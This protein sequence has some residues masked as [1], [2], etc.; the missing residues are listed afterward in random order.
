M[1]DFYSIWRLIKVVCEI[2][3]TVVQVRRVQ[4]GPIVL[5]LNENSGLEFWLG[6]IW[7]K[8][9]YIVETTTFYGTMFDR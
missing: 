6:Y 7:E 5:T 3:V 4:I 1:T 2:V 8:G 9:F